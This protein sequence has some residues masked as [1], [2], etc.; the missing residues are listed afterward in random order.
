M[1]K[2]T[3]AYY[4]FVQSAENPR[5]K[6]KF[7]DN[8]GIGLRGVSLEYVSSDLAGTD[9]S[10]NLPANLKMNTVT[11]FSGYPIGKILWAKVVFYPVA[12]KDDFV[13]FMNNFHCHELHHISQHRS[14]P[15]EINR[16]SLRREK[17]PQ[18][19]LYFGAQG[20]IPAYMAQLFTPGFWRLD[21]DVVKRLN[22]TIYSLERTMKEEAA[23]LGKD[24]RRDL[25]KVLCPS[26][27]DDAVREKYSLD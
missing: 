13:N 27:F 12:F 8:V 4:N 23:R 22:K 3:E 5:V 1:A 2:V 6:Q 9:Y 11:R 14:N 21:E 25:S 7:L 16:R 20:E 26:P 10:L 15:I 18:E 24:W 19:D 17:F